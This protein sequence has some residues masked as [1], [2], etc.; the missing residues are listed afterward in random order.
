MQI[1]VLRHGIAKM[2]RAG[3]SDSERALAPEGKKELRQVLRVA[4]AV[5][6]AP[7]LILTSPYRRAIETAEVAGKVLG[8]SGDIIKTD[9]LKPGSRPEDV[10]DELRTFR[11][12]ERILLTG[13]EPQLS[14]LTGYL[15]NTP[16]LLIDL[17]P[18]S[19]IRVDVEQVGLQPRGVLRWHL[20]PKLANGFR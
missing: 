7:D 2:G 16:S 1:F 20:T 4:G 11:S 12:E 3:K 17:K 14:Y 18:G 9:A 13:H 5:G 8:Y 10:W 19:I 6:V 15:L